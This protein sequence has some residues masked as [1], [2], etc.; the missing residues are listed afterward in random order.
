MGWEGRS[1]TGDVSRWDGTGREYPSRPVLYGN[2]RPF[3]SHDSPWYLSSIKVFALKYFTKKS[4]I[5][6]EKG[7]IHSGM[8]LVVFAVNESQKTRTRPPYHRR[9]AGRQPQILNLDMVR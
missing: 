4:S 7:Q 1:W 6:L 5:M 8:L 9:G 2:S 3:D